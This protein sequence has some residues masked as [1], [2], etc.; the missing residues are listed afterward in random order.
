MVGKDKARI[1]TIVTSAHTKKD[2]DQAADAFGKAGKKL[3]LI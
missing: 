3:S 1:R 2:L